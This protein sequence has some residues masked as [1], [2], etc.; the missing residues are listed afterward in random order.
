MCLCVCL[1]LSVSVCRLF[2]SLSVVSLSLSLSLCVCL[3]SL[4]LSLCRLSLSVSLSVSLCLSVSVCLSLSVGRG[5]FQSLSLPECCHTACT[6]FNLLDLN[7]HN[8]LARPL[9]SALITK[10]H[11]PC[12]SDRLLLVLTRPQLPPEGTPLISEPRPPL[13]A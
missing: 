11:Q 8:H 12:S 1:C 10:Q 2:L 3:S 5:V 13:S 4:S 6:D 9:Q 7:K